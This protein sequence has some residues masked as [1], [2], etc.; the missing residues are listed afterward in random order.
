MK[1]AGLRV[2]I[3]DDSL[4]VVN[5]LAGM[6]NDLGFVSS[7]ASANSYNEAV[8]LID[9]EKPQVILLDIYL[10]GKSGLDL[11]KYVKENHP[12]IKTIIIT[13]KVSSSYKT[14]C[15]VTGSDHFID[16]SSEFEMVPEIISNYWES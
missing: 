2:L 1:R 10:P 4:L 16:K 3:V 12:H 9:F 11:L 13:N 15:E 5:R 6:I 8:T 14:L 7:I